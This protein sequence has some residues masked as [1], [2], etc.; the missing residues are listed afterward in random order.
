[1]QGGYG[2]PMNKHLVHASNINQAIVKLSGSG[3]VNDL[4]NKWFMDTCRDTINSPKMVQLGINHFGGLFLLLCTTALVC[5]PLLVPEHWYDRYFKNRLSQRI[6]SIFQRNQ[7]NTGS[8]R[9]K[10]ELTIANEQLAVA[11]EH[12]E[13]S[14]SVIQAIKR[15]A[16]ALT[17]FD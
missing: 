9:N 16:E 4:Y 17:K 10:S 5:F 2:F 3:E 6:K 13:R 14:F 12:R 11:L 15:R 8:T 1:M 7:K